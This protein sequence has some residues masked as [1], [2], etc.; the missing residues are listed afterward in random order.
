MF[1]IANS[2]TIVLWGKNVYIS[3]VHLIPLLKEAKRKGATIIL[4]DPV[5]HQTT[6]LS[7]LFVQPRAGGDAA[8]ACGIARWL[9]E[10]EHHDKDAEFYCDHFDR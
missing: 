2:R 10:N 1:D 6:Q 5:H 8:L 4:I 3:S 7:D 9:L